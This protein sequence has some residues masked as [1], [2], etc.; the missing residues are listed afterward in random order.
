MNLKIWHLLV[1]ASVIILVVVLFLPNKRE[2]GILLARSGK[3]EK[4]AKILDPIIVENP[5][6]IKV[7]EELAAGYESQNDLG[8]AASLYAEY[9][10]NGGDDPKIR[11]RL[12]ALY[13]ANFEYL[14]ALALLDADM[15][16][17]LPQLI[18]L[19]VKTGDLA[20]AV[21]YSRE[22]LARTE[23]K[24]EQ[25]KLLESIMTYENWQLNIK[26]VG[27]ALEEL[28]QK[29]NTL[30]NNFQALEFYVWKHNNNKMRYFAEHVAGFNGLTLEQL[31]VLRTV[32]IRLKDA[33]N[34]L[35][36]AEIITSNK[37]AEY[38]DW[39]DYMTLLEWT[40]AKD[41]LRQTVAELLKKYPDNVELYRRELN[42]LPDTDRSL[43]RA[44]MEEKLYKLTGENAA[45]IAA[46]QIYS[47][48]K[49]E[50][51]AKRIYESLLKDKDFLQEAQ[52]NPGKQLLLAEAYW[53]AGN[54]DKSLEVFSGLYEHIIKNSD[55]TQDELVQAAA[56]AREHN[57]K[58][59]EANIYLR[60][61]DITAEVQYLRDARDIFADLK[62]DDQLIAADKKL[63][64]IT[65]LEPFEQLS[66]VQA[67]V[68][69]GMSEE[70]ALTAAGLYK[71][72]LTA[73]LSTLDDNAFW[74]ALD[75]AS[76]LKNNAER[77][78]I[79]Q[80]FYGINSDPELLRESAELQKSAGNYAAAL[81]DYQLLQKNDQLNDFDISQLLDL[82]RK[83]GDMKEVESL[84][85][86]VMNKALAATDIDKE[87]DQF[88][89]LQ[90]ILPVIGRKDLRLK[91]LQKYAAAGDIESEIMLAEMDRD[92]KQLAAAREKLEKII[93]APGI[94]QADKLRAE[95]LLSDII[96][97][98]FFA[99]SGKKRTG[100]AVENYR[101]VSSLITELQEDLN[102]LDS[103]A[104]EQQKQEIDG[105]L[106]TLIQFAFE[107]KDY[108]AVDKLIGAMYERTPGVYLELA[109]LYLNAGE[110]D[111]A[112]RYFAKIKNTD[113]FTVEQFAQLG[114]LYADFGNYEKAL[115]FYNVADKKT[116]GLDKD[117]RLGMAT[118]Y[119]RMGEALKQYE[120]V[121]F[122]TTFGNATAEDWLRAA[123][124]RQE[125]DD[126]VGEYNILYQ[127]VEKKSD[128]A[129][130][131]ARL[132]SSLVELGKNKV[133][134]TYAEKL[135][136]LKVRKDERE[137]LGVGYGLLA[138]GQ[139]RE[140]GR[141]F[142]AACKNE[143]AGPEAELA[144][145][146][147][148]AACFQYPQA[149]RVYLDY[150]RNNG[151]DGRVWY[152]FA[153]LKS[154]AGFVGSREAFIR[155]RDLLA[156]GEQTAA[157]LSLISSIDTYLNRRDQAL[158]QAVA[159][160]KLEPDNAR[161]T[162]ALAELYNS[163]NYPEY[164]RKTA[165]TVVPDEFNSSR[166]DGAIAEAELLSRRFKEGL[167][168]LQAV[169]EAREDDSAAWLAKGYN[170]FEIGRWLEGA[171]DL[172]HG[173]S[174]T[175]RDFSRDIK[176]SREGSAA[177]DLDNIRLP[178][179]ED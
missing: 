170:E 20:G 126:L 143:D 41:T 58:E 148:L 164:G 36:T 162:L 39:A 97:L 125:H 159:A 11:R 145:A 138:V 73:E 14:K 117:V 157:E 133:A 118:V 92:S 173:S 119:G 178:E 49:A 127:G 59:R 43:A 176:L 65:G 137:L 89:L 144:L 161:N 21:K 146:R 9:F 10:K 75:A 72:V 102:K 101:F 123:D 111:S 18:D 63:L 109:G 174:L 48:N 28:A 80:R 88:Y 16:H 82:Y 68:R 26:G 139:V 74:S 179:L 103:A 1:F 130:L 86:T 46:L 22:L 47:E 154:E 120:I 23:S 107:K 78:K 32:W 30:E 140:A 177:V 108:I 94:A 6:D 142:T 40:G 52:K 3:V 24:E 85:V 151:K 132:V 147:Y 166:R 100:I 116:K 134:I 13:V 84:A 67:Y 156:S 51:E 50:A 7:I 29:D 169:L 4:A 27:D 95:I 60:I 57:L 141:L 93:S 45:L 163:S 62:L 71:Q 152:E 70:A 168:E 87:R 136:G 31:R 172:Y 149:H 34:A 56:F 55:L 167:K 66:L 44:K 17:N 8:A 61:F 5:R 114:L 160:V 33:G 54:K 135:Q 106:R 110:K 155:A 90:E 77:A 113:G 158:R 105:L 175:S 53:A 104:S 81:A 79:L 37:E 150:L 91:L 98:E 129:L 171:Q 2:E 122:Y 76:L 42:L 124:A 15:E 99:A 128:S 165:L 12:V 121:D 64:K 19:S 96:S 38:S 69:K 112:L 35:K 115:Q 83:L 131:L 153:V 25:V